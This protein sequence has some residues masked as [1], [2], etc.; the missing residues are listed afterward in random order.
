MC[1]EIQKLYKYFRL[2]F[3]KQELRNKAV[4]YLLEEAFLDLEPYF[5]KLTRN[6][7]KSTVEIET[8]CVTLKDYFQ[9]R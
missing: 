8:I 7:L 9:V 1:Q 6:W 2:L 5:L 4:S 3:L